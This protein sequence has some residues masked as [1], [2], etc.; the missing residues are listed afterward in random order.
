ML[1][2]IQERAKPRLFGGEIGTRLHGAAKALAQ[3]AIVDDYNAVLD[4]RC[5][6]V[7]LLRSLS[8]KFSLR[9][10]GIAE[11]AGEAHVLQQRLPNAEI[12]C[13]RR[14]DIPWRDR[15]FD[16][17]FYRINKKEGCGGV[18]F[19]REAM[20]VLRPNGQ[21][22]IALQGMPEF[23]YGAADL[24]GV[25]EMEERLKPHQLMDQME[26]AGFADVSYRLSKPF[27]GIAMGWKRE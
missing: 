18:D 13:A 24:A 15:C 1:D 2:R 26:K 27:V 25:G 20:R 3:W 17:V 9:A 16:T 19:L 23:L 21:L 10:C 5:D 11:N 4:M 6:D 12:F 22:L 14:E 7:A 8:Q